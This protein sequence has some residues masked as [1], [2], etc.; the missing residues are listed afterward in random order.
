M[1]VIGIVI[2][3]NLAAVMNKEARARR[4]RKKK[5][6]TLHHWKIS[7]KKMMKPE[8]LEILIHPSNKKTRRTKWPSPHPWMLACLNRE[9][10]RDRVWGRHFWY[11]AQMTTFRDRVQG[12]VLTQGEAVKAAIMYKGLIH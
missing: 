3:M 10:L 11:W 8:M 12:Q 1:G 5:E 7:M 4:S 9:R 2:L 6:T